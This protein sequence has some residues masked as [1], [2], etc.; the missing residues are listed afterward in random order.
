MGIKH[1]PVNS[2]NANATGG[3]TFIVMPEGL[4]SASHSSLG[5]EGKHMNS[6]SCDEQILAQLTTS[7]PQVLDLP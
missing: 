5:L 3:R 6:K 1:L 7:K 2:V 4:A